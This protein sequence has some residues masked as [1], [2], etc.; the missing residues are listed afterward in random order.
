MK[1]VTQDLTADHEMLHGSDAHLFVQHLLCKLNG[2]SQERMMTLSIIMM[3]LC[4]LVPVHTF[5]A[6]TTSCSHY[7]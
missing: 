3:L 5:T 7:E 6:E 1:I 4:A 2:T